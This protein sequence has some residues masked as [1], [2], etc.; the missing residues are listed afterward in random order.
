MTIMLVLSAARVIGYVGSESP[1]GGE[2]GV[3]Q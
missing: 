2:A 1:G 3:A